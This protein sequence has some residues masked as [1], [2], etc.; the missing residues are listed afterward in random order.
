MHAHGLAVGLLLGLAAGQ[1]EPAAL[2]T[3]QV[4]YRLTDTQHVLVRA[5]INGKGPYN[6]IIDTGAPALFVSTDVCKKIGVKP[7]KD[8]WG[9][10]DRFEIEGGVVEEKARGRIE[11][12][13]QLKGMNGLGLAGA[14]LHGIIGYTVLAKYRIEFDFTRDKM[15]WTKLDFQPPA[16][17]GLGG[18]TGGQGGLAAIGNMMGALGGLMGKRARP[19]TILRGFL[20]MELAETDDGVQVS[21]VLVGGPAD[22][23][24]VKAG[25][26]LK[27]FRGKGAAKVADVLREGRKVR[28]G[29]AV[30]LAVTRGGKTRTFTVTAGEGF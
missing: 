12:P 8:D 17:V 27:S 9:A 3:Y 23:A 22:L 29:D 2:K 19:E 28:K 25:D 11:D 24:G 26:A 5:K 15:A 7:E 14:E 30:E 6:F 21:S 13:F 1:P 4:P 16:P 10:F 18:G 20:G